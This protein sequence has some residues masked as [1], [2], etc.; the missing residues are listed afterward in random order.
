MLTTFTPESYQWTVSC[1]YKKFLKS[2][3]LTKGRLKGIYLSRNHVKADGSR[4]VLNESEVVE[5]LASKGIKIITGTE[6]IEEI[7]TYFF[8]A[9]LVIGPHGS[10]FANTIFCQPDAQI[11]E[12]CPENRI[13]VSQKNKYKAA[14]NYTQI[15]LAADSKFNIT[16]PLKD[17]HEFIA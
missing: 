13:E 9:N 4:C 6:P 14:T 11:I 16:I 7:V 2:E 10:L 17:L 12:Y 3:A 15:I 1:Y 8:R 5:F